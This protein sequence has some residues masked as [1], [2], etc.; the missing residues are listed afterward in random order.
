[1]GTFVS[2]IRGAMSILQSDSVNQ[3]YFGMQS[4]ISNLNYLG[5][6]IQNNEL[7]KEKVEE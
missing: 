6:P 4:Q 1:M 7:A 2:E 5:G 3:S